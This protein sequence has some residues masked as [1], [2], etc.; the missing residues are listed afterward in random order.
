MI[1]RPLVPVIR[2]AAIA[3]L[4]L[5]F[6]VVVVSLA[7]A[8]PFAALG[9]LFQGGLGEP[10][11]AAL[12]FSVWVPLLIASAALLITFSAGLWNI[13]VEGQILLGAIL[14]T[15]FLRWFETGGGM[16]LIVLG[17]VMGMLGGALWAALAGL[18]RSWGR[19]HEIFS[20]LGL[21]FVALGLTLYL[22]FGPWKRP[23]VAS[24]SGTQ[25]IAESLWLGEVPGLALTPV[26]LVLAVLAF[27]LVTLVLTYSQWGLSLKAVG[28][29][30]DAARLLGLKPERRLIEAMAACGAL[31]G[32]VGALQV[33]GV[34]HR[35]I[36]SIS[37][38][39]GYTA[40]LVVMMA[41]YRPPYL[42]LIALFFAVLNVGSI[43]L[44][45][46]M[47]LDSSLAGV[48]Q[49]ALVLAV[50]TVQGV[51]ALIR[52]RRGIS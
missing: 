43:Q 20:G 41:S 30:P 26:S 27:T 8:P 1:P 24:M 48:I 10:A 42:P 6:T 49:G 11:K 29:N 25:P 13:G 17:V 44:P 50:F 46:Q 7:G 33:M 14:T 15:G 3:L 2:L 22:I 5:L 35:L 47:E 21:N 18:L 31:A 52:K 9:I 51:E 38:N 36:P 32:L 19:V 4:A 39:Y 23:G 40:L 45:L 12:A 34:Y 28:Q 37:S 16:H